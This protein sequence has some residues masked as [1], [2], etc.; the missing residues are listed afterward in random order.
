MKKP[1]LPLFFS[2]TLLTLIACQ[3]QK[4]DAQQT[5]QTEQLTE[6]I[7]NLPAYE[8]SD[9]L[10]QGSR[11]VVYTISREADDNL[12]IV[13]DE[14]GVKFKDNRYQLKVVK[15]G[16][17]LFGRSFTKADFKSHLSGEIE[18]YGI[19]DGMRFNYAQEG[20]LYFNACI[21]LPESDM[22]CPFILTIGP[23]GSYTIE[24][25]TNFGEESE[26]FPSI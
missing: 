22:T 3:E 8:Y 17:A 4:T 10:M 26:D 1:F 15:D 25:D 16:K 19:M 2:F 12:P 20:K 6:E 24:V 18:K 14:Y 5:V 21:S 13:E 9:S 11:K 7:H 23:D